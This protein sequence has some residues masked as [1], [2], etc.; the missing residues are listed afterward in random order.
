MAL[1][2]PDW[3]KQV[4]EDRSQQQDGPWHAWV[5]ATESES[6]LKVDQLLDGD[7]A[8]GLIEAHR[9]AQSTRPQIL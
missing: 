1:R 9:R 8:Q 5:V 3:A 7:L 4:L 6:P 2:A